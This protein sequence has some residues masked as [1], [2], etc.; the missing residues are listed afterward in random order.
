MHD[1][2]MLLVKRKY[3]D[4][5]MTPPTNPNWYWFDPFGGW[6][7]HLCALPISSKGNQTTH[8]AVKE[9]G[10]NHLKEYGLLTYL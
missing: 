6:V 9:H 4:G 8:S 3:E 7:C 5:G 10:I 1:A 2:L